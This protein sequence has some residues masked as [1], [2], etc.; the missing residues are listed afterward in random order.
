VKCASSDAMLATNSES[1]VQK[2]P[3]DTIAVTRSFVFKDTY[4]ADNAPPDCW[5]VTPCEDPFCSRCAESNEHI[6][7]HFECHALFV[8]RSPLELP[9]TTLQWLYTIGITRQPWPRARP[10]RLPYSD[11]MDGATNQRSLAFVAQALE[12]PILAMLPLEMLLVVRDVS[13]GGWFWRLVTVVSLADNLPRR[14]MTS[15]QAVRL[16]SV[17]PWERGQAHHVVSPSHS[18]YIRITLDR[19]GISRIERLQAHPES[20]EDRC[21]MNRLFI[22][23]GPAIMFKITAR[24]QVR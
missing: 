4:R 19:C 9:A 8:A 1:T 17:G 2:L 12:L 14:S 11:R 22:L 13:R 24:F 10:L 6:L 20:Q 21:P 18:P 5:L 3:D 7:N 16:G 15:A 23:V